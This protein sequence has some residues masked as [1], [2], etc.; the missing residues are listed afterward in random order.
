[1]KQ[2]LVVVTKNVYCINGNTKFFLK[3]LATLSQHVIMVILF[4]R[5]DL[6]A[7]VLF[8]SEAYLIFQL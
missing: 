2:S 6:G 5:Q 8:S 7:V 4:Q 3:T 1:M